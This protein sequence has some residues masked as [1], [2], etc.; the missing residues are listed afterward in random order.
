MTT[1]IQ[2]YTREDYNR[3]QPLQVVKAMGRKMLG[4]VESA[5]PKFMKGQADTI[6]RAMYTE[7][8]KNPKLLDA[9]PMTL[10]TACIHA[11]A[12]G[13]KIGGVLGQCYLVPFKGSVQ[14]I[15]GYKGYVQLVNRSGEVG[16][17]HAET[18]WDTDEFT[19]ELGSSP[20]IRHVRRD[21]ATLKE[22]EARKA[23]HFYAT[24]QTKSGPVFQVMS[25]LECELHRSKFAMFK[26]AS[27][28]WF[29]HFEAM[30]MKTCVIK[31]CK[32]LPMSAE[33]M[34]QVD[35]AIALDPE[36]SD[37]HLP[38]PS[39]I[40]GLQE[41]P[42]DP[43]VDDNP[44]DKKATATKKNDLPDEEKE[45]ENLPAP[46]QS[47]EKRVEDKVKNARGPRKPKDNNQPALIS[48]ADAPQSKKTNP[49]PD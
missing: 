12:L 20:F 15:V 16:I 46:V 21:P 19:Y 35:K 36:E 2:T 22:M 39:Q 33:A 44:E 9:S 6:L 29:E 40:T 1:A 30:S 10:F 41:I 8:A 32:F 27:G 25:R 24:V 43:Q 14:L 42:N 23:T 18:V 49:M 28:P 38:A 5:L 13:L 17:M 11:G 34:G 31:L 37:G 3:P 48:E 26:G 45:P 47:P 4:E 7:C